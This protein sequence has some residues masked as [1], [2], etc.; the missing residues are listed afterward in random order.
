MNQSLEVQLQAT[1]NIIPAYTWY[2]APSGAL[3]FVNERC[4]EYLGLPAEPQGVVVMSNG[5]Q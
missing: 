4:A 1:L 3:A 5:L 2:A